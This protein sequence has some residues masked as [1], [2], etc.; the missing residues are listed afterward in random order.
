MF[1]G[2]GTC[3]RWLQRPPQEELGPGRY[4]GCLL[5]QQIERGTVHQQITYPGCEYRSTS[6]KDA[7]TLGWVP[8]TGCGTH[9]YNDQFRGIER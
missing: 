8:A 3:R 9:F 1:G 2:I 6:T 5:H 4:M 7:M